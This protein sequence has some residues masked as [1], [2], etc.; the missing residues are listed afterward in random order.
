MKTKSSLALAF[1][2]FFF[3]AKSLGIAVDLKPVG[4]I[5]G[6]GGAERGGGNSASGIGGLDA[7]G[8]LPLAKDV[9][10]QGGLFLSGGQGFRFGLNAG[11]V[12]NFASGKVGLFLDYE[13]RAREDFN[14]VGL[15]GTGGYYFDRFDALLSYSQPVSSVHRVGGQK[16]TGINELQGILR[17]YPTN[18]IEVNGGFLV[19]S[20]AGPG[21]R[22]NGGVG[23][24]GSVGLS[25][26]VFDPVVIQLIQA[27]FDNRERYRVTSG[28]QLIF[29]SPLQEF[30]REHVSLPTTGGTPGGPKGSNLPAP[31]PPP[32]CTY[33]PG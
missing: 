27:K 22:D 33:C 32:S 20:F 3:L 19:N 12:L 4:G 5:T 30:L 14:Y 13:H 26:K 24:G 16:F 10:L 7:F 15:R 23:V 25:F 18:E 2:V 8:L 17:F 21:R 29:G 1:I 11:P 31:P 9:G 28:I 6:F